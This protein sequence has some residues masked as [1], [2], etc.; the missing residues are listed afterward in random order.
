MRT[1]SALV[2]VGLF[3]FSLNAVKKTFKDG[4]AGFQRYGEIAV[5]HQPCIAEAFSKLEP[6]ERVMCYYLSRACYA[7]NQIMTD[8]LY[9]H[10]L[11]LQTMF[12]DL[13]NNRQKLQKMFGKQF[14]R[15]V[16][17][18]FVYLFVN[19]GPYFLREH[20]KDKR[21][22]QILNLKT[23]TV[24]KLTKALTAIGYA[25]APQRVKGLKDFLERNEYDETLTVKSSIEKSAVNTYERGFNKALFDQIVSPYKGALN[26]R[27]T[28]DKQKNPIVELYRVGGRCDQALSVAVFWLKKALEYGQKNISH[29]DRYFVESLELL[30][31]FLETGD[32]EYFKQHSRVWIKHKC[33][34]DYVFGFIETYKDPLELAGYM[35]GGVMVLT[36][37]LDTLMPLLSSLEK[38]LPYSDD[39][40]R[41]DTSIY[42][43]AGI[44]SLLFGSGEL[45]PLKTVQA[46]CLPNYTEIRDKHGSRQVIFEPMK[47]I[48]ELV[49]EPLYLQ[50]FYSA[51]QAKWL[52]EHD[53]KN[54]FMLALH[55]LLTILHETIGHGSGRFTRHCFVNGDVLKLDNKDYK[56][57]DYI[58]VTTK[59]ASLLL[60]GYEG[61]LEE[62][63]AECLALYV[64]LVYLEQLSKLG[65]LAEWVTRF[66]VAT[67]R[68]WLIVCMCMR[69]TQRLIDVPL[70]AKEVVG[71]HAIANNLIL[72]Y[73]VRKNCVS[74][75]LETTIHKLEPYQVIGVQ[76][77][78]ID[79]ATKA[80]ADLVRQVQEIKSTANGSAAQ[81]L[82]ETVGKPLN[83]KDFIGII[84]RNRA[85][86]V[87]NI[88]G[89]ALLF[90]KLEPV[91][92]QG[93]MTDVAASWPG[94]IFEQILMIEN[95]ALST[96]LDCIKK[97][98]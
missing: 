41:S 52:R 19:H 37:S 54:T 39:F 10:G 32:E 13:Y 62:L 67:V 74:I 78:D 34:I 86:I 3:C 61:A 29:F 97:K 70:D 14:V 94:D 5:L 95:D 43:N 9:R 45:G 83:N 76:V 93:N 7:G 79:G 47:S 46:Y 21:S 91:C 88:K 87:K 30:I 56:V 28:L 38:K 59:N 15:E 55:E 73:L 85:A 90:P 69:A 27:Y 20:S 49:N 96:A 92:E 81:E 75:V 4:S 58:D 53:P 57:G 25:D 36:R 51:Q 31:K 18:Y 77:N 98:A 63:R 11:E 33:R 72:N 42:P 71:E 82:I 60:R 24:D 65:F 89:I 6:E 2:L 26:A 22:P 8:Q 1:Y 80:I 35:E 16:A 84:K 44:Y 66:G 12:K 17:D 23:L 64:S 40:M 48:M 68:E 50:L